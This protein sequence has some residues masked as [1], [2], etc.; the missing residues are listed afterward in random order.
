MIPAVI[1]NQIA[2]KTGAVVR[3]FF[4]IKEGWW[5]RLIHGSTRML[6]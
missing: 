2:A 6:R 1:V 5:E 3:N 4:M